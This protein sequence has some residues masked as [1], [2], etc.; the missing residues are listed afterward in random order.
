MKNI[1]VIGAGRS[2]SSLINYLL[3]NSSKEQWKVRVG[4]VS[5]DMAKQKT[6]NHPNA[7]AFVFDINNVEQR[8]EE[9]KRADIV[10]SMLPATM[11]LSVAKDC[12]RFKNIW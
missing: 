12:I 5:L 10:I 6:A 2:T 3:D 1:F 8:E 4:D 11:H 7:H 9:I